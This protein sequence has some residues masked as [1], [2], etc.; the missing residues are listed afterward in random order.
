MSGCR[1]LIHNRASLFSD[2]FRMI[3]RAAGIESI[4]LPTCSPNP[5]PF[6]ERFVRTIKESCLERFVMIGESSLHRAISQFVPHYR[7]ERNHQGLENKIIWP[8]FTPF[9]TAGAIKCR[10]RLGGLLNYY[11]RAAAETTASRV[12]GQYGELNGRFNS[13]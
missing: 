6:A 13:A 10:R 9:P 2:D 7:R 8:E 11:R 3:L 4:R 5:N 1:Y 12:F